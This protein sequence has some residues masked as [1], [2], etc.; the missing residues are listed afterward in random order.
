MNQLVLIHRCAIDLAPTM[1]LKPPIFPAITG[2]KQPIPW[3]REYLPR[4]LRQFQV[5]SLKSSF[6]WLRTLHPWSGMTLLALGWL[7]EHD[8]RIVHQVRLQRLFFDRVNFR[9]IEMTLSDFVRPE[10]WLL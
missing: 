1:T 6:W 3:S 4:T 7:L 2:L 10:L 9:D 8:R 5:S